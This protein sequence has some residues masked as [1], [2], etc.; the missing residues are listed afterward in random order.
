MALM[1]HDLAGSAEAAFRPQ[2]VAALAANVGGPVLVPGSTGFADE[3][4]TYNLNCGFQPAMT[5]GATSADDV[6]A[7][8][9][10]A[11][12]SGMPIAV[13]SS[14]HQVVLPAHGA[15]LITTERMRGFAL[16]A[17]GRTARAEP[18]LKV[19]DVVART[20]AA[21][22]APVMGS[23]P[24]VGI[25]GY[26]LGGGQSPL[27][28]RLHGYAAD[29]VRRVNV[30]TA[31]GELR[32]VT[33]ESE[34]ELFWALLGGKGNFGVV[35]EIEF[36]LFPVTRF[37]GGG[38]YFPGERLAD[39]L[40]AWR[41]WL[42]TIPEEMTSSVA[43]QRLPDIPL[44]P[45]PLRGAFVVHLRIGYLGSAAEGERLVAPLRAA[46]PPLLDLLGEKP[47]SAV[48]DIHLDPLDP[49]PYVD[50]TT[51]LGELTAETVKALVECTGPSSGCQLASMEIRSLGGGFDREPAVPNSVSTRGVP[52]IVFGVGV[53]GPELSDVLREQLT[54]V[55]DA[56]APWAVE[57]KMVNF[58]SPEEATSPE[59]VRAVYG[60]QRYDRLAAVKRRFD[61]T[62]VFRFNHNVI[63]A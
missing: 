46:A 60:P 30:V 14:A 6:V 7:A 61:P 18:G 26:T 39:V 2:D 27:L 16:D 33:A 32:N 38:I 28:G 41:T 44:L 34:P 56:L 48:G 45:E 1:T 3:C 62:N 29:H 31:D 43:I 37:F 25:V 47:V 20:S 21:G 63:P 5:V 58:L 9:R 53:G 36:G 57:Q 50:R 49:M 8:V 12:R 55:M 51:S 11:A 22:L 19:G 13:K 10:F 42:P 23:A 17:A 54:N 59:G 52:F 40:E 24:A 15:M 35:T 4:A